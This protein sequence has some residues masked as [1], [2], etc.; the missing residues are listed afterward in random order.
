MAR[1]P[2][3]EAPQGQRAA[4]PGPT[5]GPLGEP[6]AG[7]LPCTPLPQVPTWQWPKSYL[8]TTEAQQPHFPPGCMRDRSAH[9]SL[10]PLSPGWLLAWEKEPRQTTRLERATPL[11][12]SQGCR[13]AHRGSTASCGGHLLC[14][15]TDGSGPNAHSDPPPAP[16]QTSYHTCRDRAVRP[17]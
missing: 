11:T 10:K 9:G 13:E 15:G 2:C 8:C 7:G 17:G 14:S 6:P 4:T 5:A 12:R 3:T 16:P 1:A